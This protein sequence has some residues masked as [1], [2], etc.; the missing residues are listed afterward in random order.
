MRY[1]R[2]TS[3]RNVS[4]PT[5]TSPPPLVVRWG[6]SEREYRIRGR[7]RHLTTVQGDEDYLDI[8]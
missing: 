7:S 1:L 6:S 5:L 8:G 3:K 2:I 4:I